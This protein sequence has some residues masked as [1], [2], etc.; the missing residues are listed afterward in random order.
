MSTTMKPN[1]DESERQ[2]EAAQKALSRAVISLR[3]SEECRNFLRDLCTPAELQAL[4]DRWQ[5]V[6]LLEE[7]LTYRRINDLTGVSVTTIGRVARFLADG[8]GGYRTAIDRTV[9]DNNPASH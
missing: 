4:V 5:V 6:E 2:K 9:G 7:G 1:R 8:Y 3:T